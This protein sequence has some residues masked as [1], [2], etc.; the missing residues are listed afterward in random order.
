MGVSFVN[1]DRLMKTMADGLEGTPKVEYIGVDMD[2]G[3]YWPLLC[4]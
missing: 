1:L 3:G 2:E 4:L